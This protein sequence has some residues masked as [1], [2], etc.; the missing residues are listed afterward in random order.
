MTVYGAAPDFKQA[1]EALGGALYRDPY[2][3]PPVAPVYIKPA[4]TL[5][6]D[7]GTIPCPRDV[8]MLR[9]A[10]TFGIVIG[11]R[12]CQVAESQAL[13]YIGGYAV[14]NDVSI[15]HASYLRP[16]I[17]EE[18]R[19]R[20]CPLGARQVAKLNPDLAEIR[21]FVNDALRAVNTTGNLVRSAARLSEDVTEFMT[22]EEGDVLLAGEPDNSP[23][24]CPG[25][26][27]RAEVEEAGAIGNPVVAEAP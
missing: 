15:P 14:A 7:R 18:C 23:L 10:V 16:A 9:M 24:A 17:R 6:G 25:D 21:I 19:D 2:R 26:V 8:A 11:R 5:I 22:L 27:V 1:L 20:F 12:A 13:G 3:K 4:N